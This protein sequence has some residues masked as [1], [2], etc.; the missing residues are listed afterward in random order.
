MKWEYFVDESYYGMYA[1]RPVGDKNFN[2]PRL[3]HF[4]DEEDAIKCVEL[5]EKAHMALPTGE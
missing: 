5:M 2:S 1:V 4:A 3:F